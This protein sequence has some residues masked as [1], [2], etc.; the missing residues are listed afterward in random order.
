MIESYYQFSDALN[1]IFYLSQY[2]LLLQKQLHNY[3]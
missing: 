2:L 3:V 1:A